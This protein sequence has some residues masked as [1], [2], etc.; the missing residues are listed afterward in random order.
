MRY[1]RF[2][3]LL[4]VE[5]TIFT[6]N[7]FF[8]I[9]LPPTLLH[10]GWFLHFFQVDINICYFAIYHTLDFSNWG[11][12]GASM[13]IRG[14]VSHPIFGC[15]LK[16]IYVIV[17]HITLLHCKAESTLEVVNQIRDHLQHMDVRLCF[18]V[19][20]CPLMRLRARIQ[21]HGPVW[22]TLTSFCGILMS[23]ES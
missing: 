23:L 7:V 18:C 10:C 17:K 14:N 6:F 20:Q 8:D 12:T 5:D 9:V 1:S 16:W 4:C 19:G 13:K 22:I 15:L 2:M 3:S 21:N 11:L